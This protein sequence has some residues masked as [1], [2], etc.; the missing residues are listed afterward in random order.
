MPSFC[1]ILCLLRKYDSNDDEPPPP[2]K[3]SYSP[4]LYLANV[5]KPQSFLSCAM[6]F[7]TDN[8]RFALECHGH[9]QVWFK[10]LIPVING[11]VMY[12]IL[13][14]MSTILSLQCTAR[15]YA[16]DIFALENACFHHASPRA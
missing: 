16:V 11:D 14:T 12:T 15:E 2:H 7:C 3:N 1:S 4:K 5:S 13:M 9:L 6:S 10:V 8:F